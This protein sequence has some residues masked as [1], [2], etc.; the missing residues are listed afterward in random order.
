MRK[1]K[2]NSLIF[3]TLVC[4]IGVGGSVGVANASTNANGNSAEL[5]SSEESSLTSGAQSVPFETSR[6]HI[7]MNSSENSSSQR[8]SKMSSVPYEIS[9]KRTTAYKETSKISGTQAQSKN[10]Q[11]TKENDRNTSNANSIKTVS[12]SN[13]QPQSSVVTNNSRTVS[14]SSV[15]PQTSERNDPAIQERP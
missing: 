11:A 2:K 1:I 9:A 15:L 3:A 10:V 14:K 13:S 4:L 5:D 12:S 6:P 8:S 7:T